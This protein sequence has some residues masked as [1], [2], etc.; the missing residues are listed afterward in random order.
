MEESQL[1]L[2][3]PSHEDITTQPHYLN[4]IGVISEV[5]LG[6]IITSILEVIDHFDYENYKGFYDSENIKSFVYPLHVMEDCYPNALTRL[7]SVVRTWGGDWRRESKQDSNEDYMYY[8]APIQNDTLCEIAK[9]THLFNGKA[10]FLIIHTNAIDCASGVVKISY[11]ETEIEVEA[12]EPII[13]AIAVWFE[14]NRRPFRKFNLN[15]KHGE[16]G[17]GAHHTHKGDKV[18]LLMCSRAEASVLLHKAIGATTDLRTLYFFDQEKNQYIEFK[19]ES[20]NTYHAFHLDAD[21]ESRIP[22]I[23]K[24]RIDK[25]RK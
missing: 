3:F 12:K 6:K 15:P 16:N 14:N 17:K 23:I 4:S 7:R 21:D 2:L 19:L 8:R 5:E 20:D 22:K 10:S 18:S 24:D 13:P 1:F 9:R 25:V 11:N